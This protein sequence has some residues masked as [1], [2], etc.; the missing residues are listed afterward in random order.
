MGMRDYSR[1]K[2]KKVIGQR[3]AEIH[4]LILLIAIAGLTSCSSRV[5]APQLSLQNQT[6]SDS[7]ATIPPGETNRSLDEVDLAAE[8]AISKSCVEAWRKGLAGDQEG[9]VKQLKE[10]DKKYPRVS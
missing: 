3:P 2:A 10:L 5:A 6:P 8:A 1:D 4:Q 7:G 9:A